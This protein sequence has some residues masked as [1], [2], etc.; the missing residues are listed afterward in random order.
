MP[1]ILKLKLNET[2]VKDLKNAVSVLGP[3]LGQKNAIMPNRTP[4]FVL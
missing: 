4:I 1:T 3:N 2:I